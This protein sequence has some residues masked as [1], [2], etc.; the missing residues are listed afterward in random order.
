MAAASFP[1]WPIVGAVIEAGQVDDKHNQAQQ[2][3]HL[4]TQ[5]KR[6]LQQ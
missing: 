3:A 6:D 5:L 4:Q 1:F 2:A